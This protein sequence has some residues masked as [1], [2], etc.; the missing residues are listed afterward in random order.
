MMKHII[1]L[2][3]KDNMG[4]NIFSKLY[5]VG[6]YCLLCITSFAQNEGDDYCGYTKAK[7]LD[8]SVNKTKQLTLS[9]TIDNDS[10]YVTLFNTTKDTVYLFKSY[11]S[12]NLYSSKFIHRIDKSNKIYNISFVPLVSN[13]TTKLSDKVILGENSVGSKGQIL[14][15]FITFLPNTYYTLG[16]S[17]NSLFKNR[18]KRNN[19][20]VIFNE[21]SLNKFSESKFKL[22]STNKLKGK[23]QLVVSVG[24]YKNI[25]KICRRSNYYLD[26]FGFDEQAKSFEILKTS[27]R[28]DNIMYPFVR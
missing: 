16:I 26:E 19:A 22:L 10:L 25:K 24:V 11:F 13:L 23:F 18:D 21:H 7:S 5:L 2:L 20:V 1:K 12:Q 28:L 8:L 15:D 17:L 6:I 9:H 3:K 4:T 14:Y 27:I